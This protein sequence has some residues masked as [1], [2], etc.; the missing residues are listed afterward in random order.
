MF[1]FKKFLHANLQL[2]VSGRF[3]V[4]TTYSPS[5][6]II[7]RCG[8]FH[9]NATLIYFVYYLFSFYT[10]SLTNLTIL[11]LESTT[12]QLLWFKSRR[13]GNTTANLK[14][15]ETG[16]QTIPNCLNWMKIIPVRYYSNQPEFSEYR[17]IIIFQPHLRIHKW[18]YKVIILAYIG[19]VKKRKETI[20]IFCLL[21]SI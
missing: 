5:E 4:K 8:Y 15:P 2:T 7:L 21:H 3:S 14:S 13:Y 9:K 1:D 16:S 19:N 20:G 12:E 17:N 11:Q 10:K 6:S 18:N